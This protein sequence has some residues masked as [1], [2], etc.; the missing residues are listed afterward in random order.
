[1]TSTDHTPCQ[2]RPDDTGLDDLRVLAEQ[3]LRKSFSL[4]AGSRRLPDTFDRDLWHDLETAGLTRLTTASQQ[5]AGPA[6]LAVVLKALGRH[7][8]TV[9]VAETDLLA[10]HVGQRAG[11]ALPNTGAMTVAV[12]DADLEDGVLTGTADAVPWAR[13]AAAIVVVVRMFQSIRVGVIAPGTPGV[14]ITGHTNLAGEARD[15]L[16]FR[17]ALNSTQ[18]VNEALDE[19]I[20]RRGA[21]ARCVQIVG[22]LESAA[23]LTVDHCRNRVQFGRPLSGFQSVQHAL[24]EMT[25]RI[26]QARSAV[27]LAVAA[28]SDFG[29]ESREVDRSASVAK[30]VVGSAVSAV[31]SIAHQLHGAIGVTLEHDLR[32]YTMRAQCWVREFGTTDFHARRVGRQV[33]ES[34]DAWSYVVDGGR[35]RTPGA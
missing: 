11:L 22:A 31:T 21:W 26:D 19:Q 7:A 30:V 29:F 13:T 12:A 16:Y 18:A 2:I 25:G 23:K 8:G 10:A 32:L 15:R 24:A 34:R 9:P 27:S 33:L 6:E 1:M 35:R 5:E 28:A 14:E 17:M 4:R 3:I 20:V